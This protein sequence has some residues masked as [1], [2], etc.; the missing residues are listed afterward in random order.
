MSE[1]IKPP[2]FPGFDHFVTELKSNT[3]RRYDRCVNRNLSQQN[4]QGLFKRNVISALQAYDDALTHLKQ[5][6]DGA[7][8]EEGLSGLT[9]HMLRSFDGFVDELFQ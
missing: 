3:L 4:W 6:V 8:S 9:G 2:S 5:V 1:N 7:E